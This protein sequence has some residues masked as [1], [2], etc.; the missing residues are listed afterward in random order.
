MARVRWYTTKWPVT[1]RA[2]AAKMKAAAFN[3]GSSDGFLIDRAREALIEGQYIEKR[4][5]E[6][7]IVDPFGNEQRTSFVEYRRVGFRLSG[8]FPEIEIGNAPRNV[9][10]FASRLAEINKFALAIVPLDVNVIRWSE[11]L[12]QA[13]DFKVEVAAIQAGD[14]AMEDGVVG[15][16][17]LRGTEALTVMQH[18]IQGRKHTIE[19]VVVQIGTGK[20]SNSV[21]LC[22]DGA[23][24]FGSAIP[25]GLLERVR[26]SLKVAAGKD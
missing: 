19:R 4:Q 3:E 26:D 16:V 7:V 5:L 20:K 8:D 17:F 13:V 14:I 2:V 22:K 24:V 12:A 25:E 10:G 23:A 11:A 15:K 1:L 18:L 9:Q 21:Q 6:D